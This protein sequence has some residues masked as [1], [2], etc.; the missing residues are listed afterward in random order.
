MVN[1][2]G[3]KD[4]LVPIDKAGR[5][6]LPKHVRDELAIHP[7]DMLKVTIQGNEVLL[8]PKK[9]SGGLVRRGRAL[10]FSTGSA[11]GRL[12]R[13]TVQAIIDQERDARGAEVLR[14]LAPRRRKP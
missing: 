10:V 12:D 11:G 1:S 4:V 8:Q 9:E 13:D 5:V 7:G 3:M 2:N 6:V 14:G